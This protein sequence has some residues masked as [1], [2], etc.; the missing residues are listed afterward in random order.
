MRGL[1]VYCST[2]NHDKR[3]PGTP[4]RWPSPRWTGAGLFLTRWQS[5]AV[6]QPGPTRWLSQ[7]RSQGR[8]EQV[9]ACWRG[10][11]PLGGCPPSAAQSNRGDFKI[12]PHREHLSF[13]F[14]RGGSRPSV[15][16]LRHSDDSAPRVGNTG[17]VGV[18]T[19][20]HSHGLGAAAAGC[21]GI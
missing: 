6:T 8:R 7:A 16:L 9:Q 20:P 21:P 2:T 18:Q 12:P 13:W 5:A 10:W 11:D 3:D 19:S 17:R 4:W 1:P 15:R 14:G